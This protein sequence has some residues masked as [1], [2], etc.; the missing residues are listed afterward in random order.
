MAAPQPF[1][2]FQIEY[3]TKQW[4]HLRWV[5]IQING[6]DFCNE[7]KIKKHKRRINESHS[8]GSTKVCYVESLLLRLVPKGFLINFQEI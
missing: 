1:S 3:F 5:Y 2:Y 7:N 6:N 8:T 4:F